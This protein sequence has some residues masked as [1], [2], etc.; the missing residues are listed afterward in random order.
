MKVT[1]TYLRE[2]IRESL[3]EEGGMHEAK[4]EISGIEEGMLFVI[5]SKQKKG[6]LLKPFG[7]TNDALK[8]QEMVQ[9]AAAKDHFA[10]HFIAQ[11]P[12]KVLAKHITGQIGGKVT[13][14]EPLEFDPKKIRGAEVKLR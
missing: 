10:D 14:Y 9:K 5:F 1:K 13:D 4:Y 12:I 6:K 2:L 11:L 7:V 8:A 3:E